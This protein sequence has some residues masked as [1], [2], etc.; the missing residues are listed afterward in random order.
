MQRFVYMVL[1]LSSVF[2][3][4]RADNTLPPEKSYEQ[5]S[6]SEK[7]IAKA[8]YEAMGANDEPPYPIKGSKELLAAMRVIGNVFQLSGKTS[9]MVSINSAGSAESVSLLKTDELEATRYISSV[10]MLQKYKPARCNGIPCAGNYL[11]KV[12]FAELKD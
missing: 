9:M 11:W 10:L 2:S 7:A 5:F 1:L 8:P 6:D 12:N 3:W 4:A